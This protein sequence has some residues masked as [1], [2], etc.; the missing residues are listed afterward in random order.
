MRLRITA[1]ALCLFA[2][3]CSGQSTT[4][5]Y[6]DLG[7]FTGIR[8]SSAF[9]VDVERGEIHR[10]VV[11]VPEKYADRVA[12]EVEGGTLVL[13]LRRGRDVNLRGRDRLSATVTLP[14]L[15]AVEASGA[16]TVRSDEAWEADGFAIDASGA[17]DL[18]LRL[19]VGSLAISASGASDVELAG[20]A[21][22]LTIDASG[23]SDVDAGDVVAADVTVTSSGASDVEVHADESIT[24]TASGGSDIRYTGA[25][26]R[27]RV[28]ASSG[29]DIHGPRG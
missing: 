25:A 29:A 28:S 18:D 2:I 8:A 11:T 12:V 26:E 22:R 3:A 4:T 20:R 7:A 19:D 1:T 6:D 27:V 17:S 15:D 5:A 21:S 10:A 23:A 13:R 16:S 24:A 14:A 9:H